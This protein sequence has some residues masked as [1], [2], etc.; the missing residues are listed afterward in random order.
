MVSSKN[1]WTLTMDLNLRNQ[2][3]RCKKEVA[4][5]NSWAGGVMSGLPTEPRN[6]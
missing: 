1:I 5:G 4:I 6:A 3:L 2:W